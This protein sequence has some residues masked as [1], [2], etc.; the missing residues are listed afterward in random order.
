MNKSQF[1]VHSPIDEYSVL[2]MVSSKEQEFSVV[3]VVLI[4]SNLSIYSF[5]YHAFGIV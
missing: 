3:V 4:K 1:F 2:L 5:M